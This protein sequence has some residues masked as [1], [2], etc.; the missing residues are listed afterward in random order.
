MYSKQVKHSKT[1]VV[2]IDC[3]ENQLT[4]CFAMWFLVEFWF[5]LVNHEQHLLIMEN[6]ARLLDSVIGFN[7]DKEKPNSDSNQNQWKKGKK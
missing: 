7:N 2:T 3:G 4:F 6:V 1:K 5:S